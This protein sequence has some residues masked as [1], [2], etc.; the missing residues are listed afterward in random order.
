MSDPLLYWAALSLDYQLRI[1][2]YW[3]TTVTNNP[4]HLTSYWTDV[5]PRRHHDSRIIRGALVPWGAYFC[6]VAWHTIEQVE[7]GDTLTHTFHYTPWTAATTRWFTFRGT[8]GADQSPSIS[9]IFEKHYAGSYDL[10]KNP[11]FE[12]WPYPTKPP[13]WWTWTA[14]DPSSCNV[15]REQYDKTHG[16]Y[17]AYL[18]TT[19]WVPWRRLY[20]EI[21]ATPYRGHWIQ[22]RPDM[23]GAPIYYTGV[24]IGI[25]GTPP[26]GDTKGPGGPGY[27]SHVDFYRKVPADATIIRCELRIDSFWHVPNWCLFDNIRSVVYPIP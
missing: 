10:F 7:A 22:I 26:Y 1:D 18:Y 6:F 21:D 17:S 19:G 5:E 4:C 27:W 23:K 13:I 16:N 20:Q 8:V 14:P 11:S 12:L 3:I 9:A 25:N 15:L 2:G 24:Y